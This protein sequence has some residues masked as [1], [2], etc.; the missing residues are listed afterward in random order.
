MRMTTILLAAIGLLLVG[1]AVTRTPGQ[2]RVT[3]LVGS[4]C[5]PDGDC[6]LVAD[7]AECANVYGGI[8]TGLG[9]CVG[10]PKP[11]TVTGVAMSIIST[12]HSSLVC[13]DSLTSYT[14]CVA[15]AS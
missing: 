8:W 14:G 9:Q 2:Q 1:L 12:T 15:T 3:A 5:L 10:C 4:C 6:A 13:R 11:P 7:E